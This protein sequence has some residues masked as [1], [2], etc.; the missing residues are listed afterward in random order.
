MIVDGS[1]YIY[2][3]LHV[4]WMLSSFAAAKT[5]GD[6]GSILTAGLHHIARLKYYIH[7][8]SLT[9]C[10]ILLMTCMVVNPA[11]FGTTE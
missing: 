6:A 2:L 9:M 8:Y 1:A 10:S 11:Y 4:N 5:Y 7:I 3:H